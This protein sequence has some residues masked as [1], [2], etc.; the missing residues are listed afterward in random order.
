MQTNGTWVSDQRGRSWQFFANQT[1]IHIQTMKYIQI[2]TYP[3]NELTFLGKWHLGVGT[4]GE[5]LPTRRGF[6]QYL[7]VILVMIMMI[8]MH[9]NKYLGG[10]SDDYDDS[11]DKYL[12]GDSD[13]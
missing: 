9:D 6:Q 4:E 13:D 2:T 7:G 10:D 8:M 1:T 12:G 3:I 5:S 11:D